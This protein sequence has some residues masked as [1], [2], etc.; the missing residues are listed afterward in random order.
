MD[1]P[2]FA[3]IDVGSTTV[4][5][6]VV[7]SAGALRQKN[8][9]RSHGRPSQTLLPL[10]SEITEACSPDSSI[11]FGFTGS[12]G[13]RIA[14]LFHCDFLNE[15]VVQPRAVD[16]LTPGAE[17][18][19]EMGGQDAKFLVLGRDSL[20]S[21]FLVDAALNDLCAAGTG[22]FLDQQALRLGI[23][24]EDFGDLALEG[25]DRPASIAGRCTVFCKSDMVH[26]QQ[27]GAPLAEIIAGVCLAVAR[28][29]KQTLI[30]KLRDKLG[31][32]YVFQGG[33]A[34]NQ[35]MVWAFEKDLGLSPGSLIV[36]EHK[37][38]V[39]ALGTALTLL[40]WWDSLS[41]MSPAQARAFRQLHKI[42]LAPVPCLDP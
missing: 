14:R 16:R 36:P 4:K 3:G 24:V 1:S 7:D 2:F 5:Y 22:S 6:V 9:V 28:N 20:G 23:P 15:I 35:G 29:F 8:Y 27:I 41:Q 17:N 11:F 38:V 40:H 31:K 32:R 39:S 18:V 42:R 21:P 33:V 37:E 34:N 26:L 12:G 19:I 30:N 10:L 13:E 25:R